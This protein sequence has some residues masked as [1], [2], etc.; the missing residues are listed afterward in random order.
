[1]D[2]IRT[3]T[4]LVYRWG[5]YNISLSMVQVVYKFEILAYLEKEN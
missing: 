4:N 5:L 1:M 2:F 3:I